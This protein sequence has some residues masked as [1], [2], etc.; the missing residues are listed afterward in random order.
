MFGKRIV[1]TPGMVDLGE[2]QYELNKA[3]GA[4]TKDHVHMLFSWEKTN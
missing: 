4:Y 2:A 1:L 3:F